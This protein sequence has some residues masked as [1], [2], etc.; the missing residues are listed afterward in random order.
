[1]V[2]PGLISAGVRHELRGCCHGGIVAADAPGSGLISRPGAAIL[3]ASG[4]YVEAS[5]SKHT[6]IR[7]WWG[8]PSVSLLQQ[9]QHH[10]LFGHGR[11]DRG[12]AD[13]RR[14]PDAHALQRRR[15]RRRRW[16]TVMTGA[17]RSTN[18]LWLGDAV[19]VSAFRADGAGAAMAAAA[20]D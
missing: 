15:Q 8:G 5:S 9:I 13:L 7:C 6:E 11:I 10:R 16:S 2:L 19:M 1:M 12:Y 14:D 3:G 4:N 18:L 20:E 17:R